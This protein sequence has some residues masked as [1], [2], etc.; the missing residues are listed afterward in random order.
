MPLPEAIELAAKTLSASF[1]T[2]SGPDMV[3]YGDVK[4]DVLVITHSTWDGL[5]TARIRIRPKYWE[6][7]EP[8]LNALGARD[9]FLNSRFASCWVDQQPVSYHMIA[10]HFPTNSSASPATKARKPRRRSRRNQPM[11][12]SEERRV[13]KECRSR[14]SP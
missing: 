6:R 2:R 8:L 3:R 10:P 9:V 13:G 12:R 11:G 5:E 1:A 4:V 14:W 7:L